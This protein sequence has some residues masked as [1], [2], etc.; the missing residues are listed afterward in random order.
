MLWRYT[1]DGPV[2]IAPMWYEGRVYFGSDNGAAYC[3]NGENGKLIWR[4][5]AAPVD[6]D[7]TAPPVLNNGRIFS[8]HPV[9]TGVIVEGGSPILGLPCCLGSPDSFCRRRRFSGKLSGH[10]HIPS[11]PGWQDARRAACDHSATTSFSTG[12]RAPQLFQ[13]KDGKDLGALKKSS[14]G[15]IVVVNRGQVMHGPGVDSRRGGI[16][17]SNVET[18][19]QVATFGCGNAMVVDQDTV[20]MLADGSLSAASLVTRK[21]LWKVEVEASLALIKSGDELFLGGV[22]VVEA[23]D[24]ATGTQQWSH[25]VPG[26]AKGLAASGGRLFVS[27]D[28]GVVI[29]FAGGV[30]KPAVLP[31][32]PHPAMSRRR[33]GTAKKA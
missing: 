32:A 27:T 18:R 20:Y 14:G 7:P 23:Y 9:R 17:A 21:P 30:E 5:P 8:R 15:S 4:V 19:E 2:R 16:A 1:T 29:A 25:N 6:A 11:D 33:P 28:E 12:T 24:A 10:R 22:D 3:L 26:R 13:R 31:H